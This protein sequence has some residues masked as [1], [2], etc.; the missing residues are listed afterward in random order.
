MAGVKD[1]EAN[2]TYRLD[3]GTAC[4][5]RARQYRGLGPLAIKLTGDREQK[6]Y[7][8]EWVIS[9][10]DGSVS[11][12]TDSVFKRVLLSALRFD[13]VEPEPVKEEMKASAAS[14]KK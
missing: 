1:I 5:A 6:V 4:Q 13:A 7:Q 9:F 3:L 2:V 8:S 10:D 12:M 14:V 11:I